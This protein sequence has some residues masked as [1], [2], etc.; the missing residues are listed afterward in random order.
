MDSINAR[1][2]TDPG[3]A[4]LYDQRA[5]LFL[6]VDSLTAA[7]RDMER[8]I[9]LDSNDVDRHCASGTCTTGPPKWPRHRPN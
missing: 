3:R 8:A 5:E 2:V 1:I 9:R 6:S 7:Q 4:N